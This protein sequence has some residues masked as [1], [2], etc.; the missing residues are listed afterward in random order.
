VTD[1]EAEPGSNGPDDELRRP[2]IPLYP[3]LFA[4]FPV[5]HLF[6]TNVDEVSTGQALAPL[7]LVVGGSLVLL[8]LGWLVLRDLRR[9]ALLVTLF[10]LLFFSYGYVA[11][12]V[13]SWDVAGVAIGRDRYVLALWAL[14][15]VGGGY[16][17]LRVRRSLPDVT[18]ILNIVATALIATSVVPIAADKLGGSAEVSAA[19][20]PS[21]A[22]TRQEAANDKRDIYYINFDRYGGEESLQAYFDFDN[23]PFLSSLESKGF[24]VAHDAH[25]NY[26]NTGHSMT[27]M[28][29]MTYLDEVAKEVGTSGDW[30]PLYG[31]LKQHQVGSFLKSQGYRYVHVGSWF[32]P[33][34]TNPLADLNVKYDPLS[35]FART[36]LETTPLEPLSKAF[37]LGDD[38][39]DPRRVAWA[40]VLYQLE[41]LVRVGNDGKPTFVLA[42]IIMPHEPYVFERDGSFLSQAEM[43]RRHWHRNYL[44]QLLFAN[45]MMTKVADRLLAGPDPSDPIIIFSSDEGPPPGSDPANPSDDPASWVSKTPRQLRQKFGILAAF[46]L[47]G[48]TDPGIS[49]SITPVNFFRK[50]LSLYLGADLP[51]L[52]D[53]SFVWTD[54][55]HLYDLIDITEKLTP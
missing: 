14:L 37:G 9:A 41:Q 29:N 17:L 30:A 24:I 2:Q 54:K 27:S 43:K 3:I 16:L 46:H 11:K 23:H 19:S 18:K 45:A 1:P 7:A 51:P 40:R 12:A 33:T 32:E 52:E 36:L 38:K 26:P 55:N 5:L 31:M 22:S 28:L 10:M 47:P 13:A 48:I 34:R 50:V 6:R 49:P 25:A 39:L 35:E 20:H 53:K 44:E 21:I 42:H 4:A 15:L 8:A